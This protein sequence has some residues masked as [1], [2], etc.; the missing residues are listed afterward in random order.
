MPAM[1]GPLQL[2]A[3]RLDGQRH[4]VPLSTVERVVGA[5]AVTPLPGAPPS[6]RGVI[7][8]GGR[9]LP[10]FCLRRRFQLAPREIMPADQFL[11]VRAA[12][13]VLALVIDDAQGLVECQ[14]GDVEQADGSVP[15]LEQFGGVVRL[16]DGLLLIHDLAQFL[17][18]HDE[19]ALDQAL[20]RAE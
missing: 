7:D 8:A 4:A 16:P 13:R 11:I 12:G 9:I 20:E 18:R 15:G 6:V 5:V 14:P 17:S 1:S 3:F 2:L 19:L 10:V